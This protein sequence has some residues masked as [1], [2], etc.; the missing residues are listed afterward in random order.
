MDP[1]QIDPSQTLLLAVKGHVVAFERASGTELWRTPI[2][3]GLLGSGGFVT[4]V[5]D[6]QYIFAH[7]GGHL[8]CL[9]LFTGTLLW[10]DKLP[11]LGYDIA[12]LALPGQPSAHAPEAAEIEARRAAAR[13]KSD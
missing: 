11:G 8:H 1:S 3:V 7:A 10:E 5:C 13:R 2:E 9:D 6:E 12:T 4:L